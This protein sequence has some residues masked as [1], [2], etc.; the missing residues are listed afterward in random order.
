MCIFNSTDKLF[1]IKIIGKCPC[2]KHIA[3]Q[4]YGI[5][6]CRHNSFHNIK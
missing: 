3:S 1:I 5:C 4:V 6:P 2:S